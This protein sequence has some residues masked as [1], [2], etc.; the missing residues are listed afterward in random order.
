MALNT[1]AGGHQ[2]PSLTN[3]QRSRSE[4]RPIP[5]DLKDEK[6]FE[7][8]RRNNVAAKKSRDVRKYREDEIATR[9][10][11][12][13]KENA[14]LRAQM[15]T[16]HEVRVDLFEVLF[17]LLCCFVLGSVKFASVVN[18]KTPTPNANAFTTTID[19]VFG[20]KEVL[21]KIFV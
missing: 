4:K 8:R 3:R 13:E 20:I 5:V 21:L 16:L 14:I 15:A 6:Y 18:A 1:A 2:S 12:L 9:A 7:R 17:F 10:A 19:D 11:F